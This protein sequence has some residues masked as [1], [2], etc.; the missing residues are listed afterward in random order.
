M[1][2]KRVTPDISGLL[3]TKAGL[4][5]DVYAKTLEVF[6]LLSSEAEQL[7][8]KLSAEVKEKDDRVRMIYSKRSEFE[9]QIHIGG[10]VLVFLMHTNVFMLDPE[11][12]LWNSAYIKKENAR[13]FVGLINVY[14]FLHDSL[15]YNRD[16]DIGYLVG[17]TL[18]NSEGHY[19]LELQEGERNN[20]QDFK[21]K[22]LDNE[23]ARCILEDLMEIVINFDMYVPPVKEVSQF[24]VDEMNQ[25]VLSQKFK[26]AK[27]L[28]F[29]YGGQE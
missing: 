9:F 16:N 22:I 14:N 11:N 2:T 5:Q 20:H 3:V 12:K 27:R 13:A 8:K 24:S 10:D 6:S 18:V 21:T 1:K 15:Y 23:C 7:M 4:K 25:A 29:S 19:F 28:G 26:T 17:R